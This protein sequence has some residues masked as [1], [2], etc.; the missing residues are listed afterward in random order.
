M[1]YTL[2]DEQRSQSVSV[3]REIIGI[4]RHAVRCSALVA[5]LQSLRT[6]QAPT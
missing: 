3:G 5:R 4:E 6:P 1:T 2:G